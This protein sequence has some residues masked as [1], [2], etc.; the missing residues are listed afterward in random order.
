MASGPGCGA[1]LIG[2]DWFELTRWELDAG[3]RCRG[4]GTPCPG[5]FEGVPGDWGAHRLPLRLRQPPPRR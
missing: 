1:L 3:G 4:C 2:R 5:V